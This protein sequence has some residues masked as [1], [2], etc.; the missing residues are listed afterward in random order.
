M[1]GILKVIAICGFLLYS[2]SLSYAHNFAYKKIVFSDKAKIDQEYLKSTFGES[3][4]LIKDYKLQTLYALSYF[5]ELKHTKIIFSKK[6][7]KTTMVCR[8]R[9]DFIFRKKEN[10]VYKII[11]NSDSLNSA[12]VT[13]D[14]LSFNSQIGVLGHEYSHILDYMQM[15]K[16]EVLLCGVLYFTKK[17]YKEKLEKRVDKIAIN[18]GLGWQIYEFSKYVLNESS[19]DKEYK[20][21]KA[22]FYY[23]PLEI[24]NILNISYPPL[25][26]AL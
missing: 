15:S 1:R 22:R 12:K 17:S 8:P 10:W 19:A 5:D 18:K 20:E 21:Y 11:F 2:F 3:K 7:I 24:N 4:K 25:K 6:K 14:K 16:F 26:S 23:T 13:F 9:W